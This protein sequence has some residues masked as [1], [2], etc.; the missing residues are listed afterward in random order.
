MLHDGTGEHSVRPGAVQGIEASEKDSGRYDEEHSSCVQHQG[1]GPCVMRGLVPWVLHVPP[2]VLHVPPCVQHQ[3]EGPCMMR[4]LVPWVLHVP[5][6]VQHQGEGV[7]H[8][9]LCVQHQ[10]DGVLEI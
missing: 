4:G 3:G 10:G 5:P 1:E 6:C 8:V 7:L 9:P 2:C